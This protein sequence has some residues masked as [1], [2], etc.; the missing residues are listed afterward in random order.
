[1]INKIFDK[2]SSTQDFIQLRTG[3][4]KTSFC[5]PHIIN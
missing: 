4:G 5:I 3:F 2:M 1:M